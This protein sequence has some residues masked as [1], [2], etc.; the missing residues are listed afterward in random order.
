M[1]KD[2]K[3]FAADTADYIFPVEGSLKNETAQ[4]QG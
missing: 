4:K 2:H 3:G 1:K